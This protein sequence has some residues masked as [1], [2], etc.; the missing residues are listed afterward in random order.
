MGLSILLTHVSRRSKT[1]GG[2]GRVGDLPR[3]TQLVR[4]KEL[5]FQPGPVQLPSPANST[6]GKR[7]CESLF[8]RAT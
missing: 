4:G 8:L 5:G 1:E 6:W 3:T 2:S 7:G